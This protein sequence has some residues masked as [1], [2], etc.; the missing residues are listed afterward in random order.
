VTDGLDSSHGGKAL[1]FALWLALG[2]YLVR[3]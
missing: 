3:Q 1:A 2:W